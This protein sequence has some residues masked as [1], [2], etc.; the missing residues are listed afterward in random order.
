MESW[1]WASLRATG[2][3][4]GTSG[5]MP[6]GTPWSVPCWAKG[7]GT[8]RERRP[9][10]PQGDPAAR[11]PAAQA[12]PA[13]GSGDPQPGSCPPENLPFPRPSRGLR[14]GPAHSRGGALRGRDLARELGQ[15]EQEAEVGEALAGLLLGYRGLGEGERQPA[16]GDGSRGEV[17]RR[18][19][20]QTG[21]SGA[22]GGA[23]RDGWGQVRL[24]GRAG[25]RRGTAPGGAHWGRVAG[26]GHSGDRDR[27]GHCT[28]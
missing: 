11:T 14:P 2:G 1:K 24:G 9:P 28:Q 20:A 27:W 4:A 3:V 23:P 22:S 17:G 16:P 10:Q 21:G 12:Q 7:P 15:H 19:E 5:E 25:I 18:A 26:G 6:P 8:P 13:R